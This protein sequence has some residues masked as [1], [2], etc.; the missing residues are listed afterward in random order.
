MNSRVSRCQVFN[1][2]GIQLTAVFLFMF[3]KYVSSQLN[4][5]KIL[6]PLV[7][8]L[9]SVVLGQF[10]LSNSDPLFPPSHFSLSHLEGQSQT[11]QPFFNRKIFLFCICFCSRCLLDFSSKHDNKPIKRHPP[12]TCIRSSAYIHFSSWFPIFNLFLVHEDVGAS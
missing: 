7:I 5:R 10:H 1:A 12:L 11:F 8:S 2:A 3:T 4:P 6:N 9:R